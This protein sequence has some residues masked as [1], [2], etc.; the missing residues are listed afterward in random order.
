MLSWGLNAVMYKVISTV[1]GPTDRVHK[2]VDINIKVKFM[3]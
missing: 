2:P 3:F 1:P